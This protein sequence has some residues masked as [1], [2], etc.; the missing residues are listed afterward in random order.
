MLFP[1]G[2]DATFLAVAATALGGH[3]GRPGLHR[4]ALARDLIARRLS[5]P[6][7]IAADGAPGLIRAIEHRRPASDRPHCAVRRL[8]KLLPK[9]PERE[10]QRVRRAY[11]QALEDATNAGDAKQRLQ[12]L[13]DELGRAGYSAAAECLADDLDA[14]VVHLRD[15]PT[16]SRSPTRA[17][18]TSSASPSTRTTSGGCGSAPQRQHEG[19]DAVPG[20]ARSSTHLAGKTECWWQAKEQV[21]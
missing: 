21:R 20:F 11:W 15:P 7:L 12:I 4:A 19:R 13:V 8:R 6:M 2:L 18:S 5:A 17:P 9:L 1:R 10:R 3:P 16:A 14:I